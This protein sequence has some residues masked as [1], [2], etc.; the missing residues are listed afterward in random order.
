[1]KYLIISIA[2]IISFSGCCEKDVV[3]LVNETVYVNSVCPEF[4]A[5]IS[6]NI[7]DLNSTHGSIS[8]ADATKLEAF[9]RAKKNF[10]NKVEKLNKK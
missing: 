5:K 3:A 10:N 9:L 4:T 1:M 8:W 6:I 7:E 2:I